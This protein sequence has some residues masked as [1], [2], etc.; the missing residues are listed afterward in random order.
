MPWRK[1]RRSHDEGACVE[2]QDRRMRVGIRDSK[3]I[4]SPALELDRFTFRALVVGV[5]SGE[6][7]S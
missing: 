6:M 1:S 2:L 7:D 5:K 4:D 3:N